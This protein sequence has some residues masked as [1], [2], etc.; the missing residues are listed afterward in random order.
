[1]R[2]TK[3]IC[4]LGPAVDD[5]ILLEKLI[6]SGM[7]VARMNFS[8]GDHEEQKKRLDTFKNVREKLGKPIP[9][10]LDT[11]G[12]EIR[13]GSFESGEATLVDG[14]AFA[15]VNEDIIGD[16]TK[17]SITYKGLYLDVKKGDH[18]LINDGLIDLEVDHIQDMDIH[19]TIL[20]GGTIGNKKG[21]NV[22]RVE[23]QLPSLTEKDISDICFGIE[24]EFDFIAASFVRKPEDIMEI[25]K[26]LTKHGGQSIKVIAKIENRQGVDNIDEILK[27]SDGIMVA[28]GD[29]GVEIPVEEV[30]LVQK[31]LIDKC[32]RN[33]KPVITATQMLDSM[34]RNPRPTRAEASD[35]ANAI[36]DGTSVIMLSGETAAGKYPIESMCTMDRIAKKAEKSIDYWKEFLDMRYQMEISVTN[37]I[38]HA[39]CTTAMDLSAAAIVT[40]TQSGRT[41]RMI[42][43]FRPACP[44]IATTTSPQVQRQLNMSWGVVPFL[45]KEAKSTDEMFDMGADIARKSDIVE[46]GDIIAITAGVPVGISGTT[47]ILKVQTV[48]KI[49]VQ[50]KGT[51]TGIFT[52]ELSV[53]KTIKEAEESFKDGNII[54]VPYTNNDILPLLRRSS[55]II[56]EENGTNVHAAVV[57]MAL[58][59]PVVIGAENATKILKNGSVVTV[60]SER[61]IV[62]YGSNKPTN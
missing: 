24:N 25:K 37:A 39:T 27:V 51:S 38:S 17:V 52:G 15:L 47:N 54:V 36:F 7:D 10:L 14:D 30:P 9:V 61:G 3:I 13:T 12:P 53:A 49:L 18:I 23:I 22:P 48:G 2:K 21:I 62:Y 31:M 32:Y 45:V 58:E 11:R 42:S 28:R 44:I 4:T 55:A 5:P 29:L 33:G 56:V 57:G 46:N 50:G 34:I 8:H 40:V 60:D 20:N 6:S 43:R 35:V 19:C 59:I 26:V 1:M 41:A 16:N